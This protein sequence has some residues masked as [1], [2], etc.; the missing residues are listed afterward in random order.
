MGVQR[1]ISQ[2]VMNAIMLIPMGFMLPI[3]FK[4]M[5]KLYKTVLCVALFIVCVETV[6]YFIGRSADVDDLIMNTLG[7]MIGYAIYAVLNKIL[8]NKSWWKNAKAIQ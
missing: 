6:Q 1:M 3:V 8:S 4:K 5:R 7:G 2:L